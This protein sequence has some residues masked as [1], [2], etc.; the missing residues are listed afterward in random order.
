MDINSLNAYTNQVSGNASS[1]GAENLTTSLKGF[2]SR[3]TYEELEEATVGF[4]SYFL[5]QVIKEFKESLDVW[6]ED[7]DKDAYA[8]Q[9]EDMYMEKSIQEVAKQMINQGGGRLTRDLTNQIARNYGIDIP[10]DKK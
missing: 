9:I 8:S 4:E 2:S 10:E 6:N 7:E 3:S 1:A 5:E